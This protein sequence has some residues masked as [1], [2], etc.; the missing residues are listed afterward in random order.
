MRI[1][2]HIASIFFIL[3]TI[4]Y[5]AS[6]ER[7][8][9][10]GIEP[11]RQETHVWCWLAVGEMVFRHYG[12]PQV[13][14]MPNS[15]AYQCGIIGSL[16]DPR[17]RHPCSIYCGNC[18]IPAGNAE[19]MRQMLEIYPV[20]AGKPILDA[21][22]RLAALS[23]NEIVHEIDAGNPVIIGVSPSGQP[24]AFVSEHVALIA[25]YDIETNHL[26]VHDPYPFGSNWSNPYLAA[27]ATPVGSRGL[28]YWVSLQALY[29]RLQWRETFTLRAR[30]RSMPEFCCTAYGR[31][32]P[33]ENPLPHLPGSGLMTG[34]TCFAQ[35]QYQFIPGQVCR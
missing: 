25:G 7:R 3:L 26:L 24:P 22:H 34:E 11:V 33:Y 29:T 27:G 6:A 19:T 9:L 2:I 13:N 23:M 15:A 14:F 10:G 16:S 8:I 32:G 4:G 18:I 12:I 5:P 1:S 20:R 35:I 31:Y 30:N 21:T 17:S 28:S